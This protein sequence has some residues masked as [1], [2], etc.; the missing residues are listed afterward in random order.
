MQKKQ[1]DAIT[2]AWQIIDRAVDHTLNSDVRSLWSELNKAT[3]E[4]EKDHRATGRRVTEGRAGYKESVPLTAKFFAVRA[5]MDPYKPRSVHVRDLSAAP[6][7]DMYRAI[8]VDL[9]GVRSD[10]LKGAMLHAC[11]MNE[12][13]KNKTVSEWMASFFELET[14]ILGIDYATDIAA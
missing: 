12:A 6:S 9:A 14:A 11:F 2:K 1:R 10:I 4:H 8:L 7:E 13:P 3:L 5:I